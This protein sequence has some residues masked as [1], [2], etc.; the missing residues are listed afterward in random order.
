MLLLRDTGAIF[1]LL[2]VQLG[3]LEAI[4]GSNL[5]SAHAQSS[6]SLSWGS[7]MNVMFSEVYTI[8]LWL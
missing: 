3:P 8:T 6:S 1:K 4:R 2:A 5:P 7:G